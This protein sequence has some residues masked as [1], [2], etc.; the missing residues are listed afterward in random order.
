MERG[1]I[2]LLAEVLG[3]T[4]QDLCAETVRFLLELSEIEVDEDE[5]NLQVG[6]LFAEQTL[7]SPLPQTL[8][9]LLSRLDLKKEENRATA[10]E[11]LGIFEN[12]FELLPAAIEV[13]GTQTSL[14]QWIISLLLPEGNSL[15][16]L[17]SHTET[18][19]YASELL[20]I[21]LQDNAVQSS[22]S[23]SHSM[24]RMVGFFRSLQELPTNPPCPMDF[25]ETI[26]NIFNSIALA[27]LDKTS[28]K[29]FAEAE[30]IDVMLR[31]LKY[32]Y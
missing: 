3:S 28:Q 29:E 1:G 15:K 27:L 26:L 14:L 7:S 24:T 8:G 9:A 2:G 31:L 23:S 21:L 16:L 6:I 25:R 10:Y 22:F 5:K 19:L 4:N 13:I 11:V 30:G 12:L 32:T 18:S 17:S 20:S